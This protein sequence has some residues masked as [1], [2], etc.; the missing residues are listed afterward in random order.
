MARH[1]EALKMNVEL[2]DIPGTSLRVSPV[3]IGTWAIGGWMWG[4]ADEA[5]SIATIRAAFEHGSNLVATAPV[6]GFG[7]SEENVGRANA[8]GGLRSNVLIDPNA[9]LHW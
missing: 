4:G 3:A 6:Y 1:A 7:R 5:E 2:T 8:D 9:G